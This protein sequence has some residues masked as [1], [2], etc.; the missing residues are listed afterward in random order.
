MDIDGLVLH[1]IVLLPHRLKDLL[2][3]KHLAGP[4][5]QQRK[6]VK[7]M[8]SQTDR[9]AG[10]GKGTRLQINPPF[11]IM[12]SV[13]SPLLFPPRVA[14]LNLDAGQELG[15]LKGVGQVIVGPQLQQTDFVLQPAACRQHDHR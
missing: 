14:Q 4:P 11:L 7:F 13:S 9:L 1:K 3:G 8:G 12:E 5:G 6:D 10:R 15:Q 2:S